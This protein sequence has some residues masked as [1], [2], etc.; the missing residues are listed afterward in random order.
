MSENTGEPATTT[1]TLADYLSQASGTAWTPTAL[2]GSTVIPVGRDYGLTS[3]SATADAA[4]A[5]DPIARAA[6]RQAAAEELHPADASGV[7]E[8]AVLAESEAPLA[9]AAVAEVRKAIPDPQ[10]ELASTSLEQVL[11]ASQQ[12][13]ARREAEL[14]PAEVRRAMAGPLGQD[15]G[16]AAGPGPAPWAIPADASGVSIQAGAPAVQP[17][18]RRAARAARAGI[19]P[20]GRPVPAPGPRIPRQPGRGTLGKV[21]T[22]FALIGFGIEMVG[23]ASNERD[24]FFLAFLPI[25]VSFVLALVGLARPPR[26]WAVLGL[27]LSLACNPIIVALIGSSISVS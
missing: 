17:S 20:D 4:T 27:V 3:T 26:G 19:G 14:L 21:S 15:A 2:P 18:S 7:P 25:A 23:I 5:A 13:L 12:E 8:G 11:A 24:T 1:R 22:V 6:P 9:D 10:S 16:A